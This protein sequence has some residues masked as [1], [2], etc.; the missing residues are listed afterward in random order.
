[1]RISLLENKH[2]NSDIYIIGTGPSLRVFNTQ[3]LSN[4]ITIGLNQAWK[5]LSTTY[6]ISVH[7]ELVIEYEKAE[8]KPKTKWIAKQKN[9][10]GKKSLDDP[11]YYMFKTVDKD[12]SI[13]TKPRPDHLFIGRGVQQTAMNMAALMGAKNIILVGIDMTDVGGDHHGHHQHVKFHGLAPVDVYAEYRYYTAKARVE[14]RKL[15]V[16]V[17]T[18][19]PFISSCDA[20]DDYLRLCAEFN[21]PKLPKPKDTSTYIRPSVDKKK[22]K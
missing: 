7:P 3:Y 13:F 15:G 10:F 16:S 6:S 22:K 4:K 19:S 18:L 14:L 12:F 20:T 5:H 11:N 9:E 2:P 21:L 17:M 8:V 1:M